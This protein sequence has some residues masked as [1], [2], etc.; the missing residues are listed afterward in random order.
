[1]AAKRKILWIFYLLLFF[2][3]TALAAT[4]GGHSFIGL[5]LAGISFLRFLYYLLFHLKKR[6][7]AVA[8]CLIRLLSVALCIL[9]IA[10]VI[11]GTL[12]LSASRG[13]APDNCKY[14][15]VLGAGVN[16]IEPS[17]SLRDRLDAA[18]M[19]LAKYPEAICI[20]SGGKGG[21]ENISEA[22]CMYRYLIRSGIAEDRI[23]KEEKA[24][25]TSENIQYSL[26][27]IENKTGAIPGDIAI[28]SSEY[29]LFRAKMFASPY[30]VTAYGIPAK[31]SSFSVQINYFLREIVAVWYYST[32]GG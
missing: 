13:D 19:Y 17:L 20:V 4:R 11:T 30:G 27:V 31:T 12:I 26:S 7:P 14:V 3:G 32:I 23:W 9:I 28:L 29:H 16:G 24:T 1:M 2:C 5:I 25:T 21:G 8:Q 15:I 10:S 6:K 18:I 22:E